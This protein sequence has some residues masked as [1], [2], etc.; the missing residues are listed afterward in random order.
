MLDYPSWFSLYFRRSGVLSL[1]DSVKEV[2]R[3]LQD[4]L[5]TGWRTG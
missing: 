5:V 4:V 1:P 2:R 3:C